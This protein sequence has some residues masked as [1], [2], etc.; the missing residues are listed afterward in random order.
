MVVR[1]HPG[2]STATPALMTFLPR[3]RPET[4]LLA[5]LSVAILVGAD[6][7]TPAG[8][9][10]AA[11]PDAGKEQ[12]VPDS[13]D[14]H[15]GAR[16]EQRRFEQARFRYM[17]FTTGSY[18]GEC[19]ERVGRF[20]VWW[21]DDPHWT[22]K[23]EA[24]EVTADRDTL[25]MRLDSIQRL[26]PGDGWVLGQRVWYRGEAG[27]W[28]GA[29]D[30]ARHCGGAQ[31]WWC[32]AL[33]GLALHGLGR[34]E[35]ADAVF[36]VALEGMP[37]KQSRRWVVPDQ[38]VDGKTAGLLDHASPARRDTLLT[39]LWLLADP[40]YLIPGNDARTAHYA[41]WT[42]ATLRE[43]GRNPHQVSWGSDLAELLV[44]N[45]WEIAWERVRS[46][47]DLTARDGVLG[48]NDPEGR[49]FM[50]PASALENPSSAAAGDLVPD[51]DRP[52]S[53]YQPAYAPLL[54]PM[55]GQLAVFPRGDSLAV[56]ATAFVP[57]DT[58]QR[59]REGQDRPW[60]DPGPD[61]GRPDEEGLFLVTPDGATV[62]RLVVQGAGPAGLIMRAPAGS[63]VVSSE[64]WSPSRR[65][66]GRLRRGLRL[67]TIPADVATISGLLL[68]DASRPEP[69]SLAAA[70]AAALPRPEVH[71]GETFGLVWEVG[72]LGWRPER[73]EYSVSVERDDRGALRRVGEL[74]HLVGRDRPLELRWTEPGPPNPQRVLRSVRLDLPELDDGAYRVR[75][76]ARL[77][78][79]AAL[80]SEVVFRAVVR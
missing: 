50:P 4:S 3:R 34:Y 14:L 73:V 69:V 76:Q 29:L 51:V 60:M 27:R 45:G 5:A 24:P 20:C 11:R 2:Q 65:V 9:Q 8:A 59:A 38:S 7:L 37:P 77:P 71:S 32:A 36:R 21:G 30:V 42:V 26:V 23:P 39:R 15:G 25:L 78:G 79:R 52:R 10:T 46:S 54:L 17:P 57:R 47:F 64:A 35:E 56:V 74:L 68:T 61:R 33:E 80:T 13:A 6:G 1:I 41:R 63:Y 19:D 44:R 16:R 55:D 62:S 58:T 53:L 31:V 28:S 43:G 49:D 12:E 48:Y 75:L 72:G 18:G 66:A 40:L 22:P 67:D 70:A